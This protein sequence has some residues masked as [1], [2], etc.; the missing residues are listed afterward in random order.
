LHGEPQEIKIQRATEIV[1]KSINKYA[2]LYWQKFLIA[3][4]FATKNKLVPFFLIEITQ[5]KSPIE[6]GL[7]QRTN[8]DLILSKPFSS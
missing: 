5:K 4:Y 8:M 2:E 6:T 1:P 3:F 7:L